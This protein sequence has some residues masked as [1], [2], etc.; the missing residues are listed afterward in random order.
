MQRKPDKGMKQRRGGA[1]GEAPPPADGQA[2]PSYSSPPASSEREA[3]RNE[4]AQLG[5]KLSFNVFAR[6]HFLSEFSG[7]AA[8]TCWAVT[9]GGVAGSAGHAGVANETQT[10][11]DETLKTAARSTQETGSRLACCSDAATL[12]PLRWSTGSEEDGKTRDVRVAGK[13]RG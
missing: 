4:Q 6:F 12:Q 2:R 1:A 3:D 5:H 7:G 9:P 13:R 11:A 10:H 8:G